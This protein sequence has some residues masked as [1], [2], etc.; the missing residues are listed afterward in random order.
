MKIN[1]DVYTIEDEVKVIKISLGCIKCD[2]DMVGDFT[3]A[4]ATDPPQYDYACSDCGNK[5][6]MC[7]QYPKIEYREVD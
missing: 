1:N 3:K 4:Y 6:I 7:G 2:G 5:I